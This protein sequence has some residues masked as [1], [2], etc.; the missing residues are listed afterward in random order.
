LTSHAAGLGGSNDPH[1]DPSL[2]APYD[3]VR[4]PTLEGSQTFSTRT[5][6]AADNGRH[7][8]LSTTKTKEATT[9]DVGLKG[10]EETYNMCRAFARRYNLT[11]DTGIL[12]PCC[13]S[14]VAPWKRLRK[15]FPRSFYE[16]WLNILQDTSYEE[17]HLGRACWEYIV[18]SVLLPGKRTRD[19]RVFGVD[20]LITYQRQRVPK[21][22][23]KRC[24]DYDL[25][26]QKEK[27]D[28]EQ[29]QE[30]NKAQQIRRLELA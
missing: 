6:D 23:M 3:Q 30:Q 20:E 5:Y 1:G 15:Q 22:R 8:R 16:E 21:K 13:A 7:R 18:W 26:T 28:Q 4:F 17:H 24:L 2:K 9:T 25:L 12:T 19:N 27:K 10:R 14:F 29:E 11:M